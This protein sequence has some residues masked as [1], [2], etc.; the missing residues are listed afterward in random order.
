MLVFLF[1]M[2]S[3]SFLAHQRSFER[4]HKKSN[5]QT[6]FNIDK[7]PTDN[8][9]RK[10]LDTIPPET[11]YGT[12]REGFELLEKHD[13]LKDF[14]V[15]GDRLLIPLDGTE[16]FSSYA[17]QC[18]N[19]N[20]REVKKEEKLHFHGFVGASLCSPNLNFVIPLEPEFITPQDG[21]EKQ[22]SERAASKRWIQK[23]G[24][25]YAS[26]KGIL[27]GDDIYACEPVCS[28]TIDVGLDFIFVCK[29]DSHKV[30]YDY[31]EGADAETVVIKGKRGKKTTYR[32]FNKIP[33]NGKGKC[34][35]N[36]CS[37]EET[38]GSGKITYKNAFVTS[39]LITK[40]NVAEI[41]RAGRSKWKIENEAF[42][43]LKTKGY[44][45]E[46]NY[47]HGKSYLAN[48]LATFNIL[49]FAFHSIAQF[50]CKKYKEIND[51]I[52]C[53]QEFFEEI[54]T[55]TKYMIFNSWDHLFDTILDSFRPPGATVSKK[56]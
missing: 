23:N 13:I 34:M 31:I 36:W 19:C 22:D 48:I 17:I 32:F 54:R 27:L 15:L 20:H 43:T 52:R 25:Y 5:A 29:P 53:R 16:F 7:I 56:A 51:K 44:N 45:L 9:I 21:H 18:E 39:L 11:F 3:P 49:A 33:L 40:E 47:G 46:H 6:L 10:I 42:N 24:A 12:F 4:T 26:K 14:Q 35:V 8:Q 41:A 1:F 55:L 30:L 37:I 50:I 2:Q 38:N 28:Q